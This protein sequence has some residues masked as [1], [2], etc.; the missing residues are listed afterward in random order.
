MR[1]RSDACASTGDGG[2]RRGALA[3]PGSQPGRGIGNSGKS[4][5]V[6]AVVRVEAAVDR[7][8]GGGTGAHARVIFV[9]IAKR[10]IG[11]HGSRATRS[12]PRRASECAA[13]SW[14]P[15]TKAEN[16]FD[17]NPRASRLREP[18]FSGTGSSRHSASRVP[19]P[20]WR[21]HPPP[22]ARGAKRCAPASVFVVSVPV[23]PPPA[24][25][26]T[27]PFARVATHSSPGARSRPRARARARVRV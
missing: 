7:R 18:S 12:V 14:Q 19:A 8:A 9:L 27:A 15:P 3:V 17:T 1:R 24:L 11:R 20:R 6:A 10:L 2:S 25:R 26:A 16:Q 4:T 5:A 22:S 13:P 21:P 23:R